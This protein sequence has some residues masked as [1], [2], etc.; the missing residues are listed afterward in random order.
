MV[1]SA[2]SVE[3]Y[4]DTGSSYAV[5]LRQAQWV[6]IGLPAAWVASRIPLRV[7]RRLST[8]G[9]FASVVL[10]V[11]TYVPGLGI[12]VNGNRNWLSAGPIRLQPSE[13]A[14]LTLA[15]WLAHVYA[16]KGAAVRRWRHLLLPMAP[17]AVVVTGLVVGQN[18]LGTALV[19]FAIVLGMVW[20]IGAPARVFGAGLVTVGG[21]AIFLASLNESRVSRLTNF[22]DPFSAYDT[23]GWQAAHGFFALANG[24]WW[25]VGLGAS[26]QKWEGKLPEAHNDF[27]YAIIGEELGLFGT[28]VVLVLFGLLAYVGFRI[29]GRATDRFSTFAAA[30]ITIWLTT[31]ALINIGMVLGML[32]VIGIP[33]P[34]V[35]YGGSAL[36][37]ALIALGLLVNIAKTE[38]GAKAAWRAQHQQGFAKRWGLTR[39]PAPTRGRPRG[40]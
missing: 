35:S 1:L 31:Q 17:V 13:L 4:Y 19:L 33:L 8:L 40:R 21:L 7:V 20:V 14:K 32:P 3:S 38:P 39:S 23:T 12:E 10:L 28:L 29:A 34:L 9:L 22:T 18:D 11:L 30:G 37:P 36:L 16:T 6:L 27:I 24:G 15:L 26:T 2:S 5:F 25:G